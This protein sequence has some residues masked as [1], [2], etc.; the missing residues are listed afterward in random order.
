MRGYMWDKEISTSGMNILIMDSASLIPDKNIHPSAK[1][2]LSHIDPHMTDSI[3]P[4]LLSQTAECYPTLPVIGEKL[5]EHVT[6]SCQ[7][8]R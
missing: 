6:E 7:H 1:I 4:T 5:C 3:N 8:A 2:F